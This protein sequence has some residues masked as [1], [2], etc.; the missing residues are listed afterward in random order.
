MDALSDGPRTLKFV[1]TYGVGLHGAESDPDVHDPRWQKRQVDDFVAFAVEAEELG[2]DGVTVTEH[3]APLM[4]CPSPHLLLAA[5]AVRTSRIRLGTAVTVLPLYHPIRVAE[6]AGTLDLLSGGR[7]ELGLGRGVPGEAH[8]AVGRRLTPEE[9]N[10]GWSESL[11]LLQLALTE[12]DFT[13]DGVFHKVTRPTTIATRPLQ[14]PFPIWLGGASLDTMGRA[15][16]R[17]WNVMRNF[18]S[19]QDHREA[20]EHYTK[21]AAEH[22]H[23]RSGANMMIERFVAVGE[24]EEQAERNLQKMSDSFGRFLSLFTAGGRRAVP[25][26]DAEFHVDTGSAKKN[27]PAI[28]VFGTPDQVIENL[29]RTID[30]TGARRLLVELFSTEDR[31][32]F[33]E[34]VM[35]VLRA[36]NATAR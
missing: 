19:N 13:Y 1:H 33:V 21:V 8:I 20:L 23:V 34:E 16:E 31:R 36:R 29:Q 22:G 28:A 11:E 6:E 26:S 30:E 25:Q 2:F 4:T 17:G 12:R 3:H 10:Q 27:R 35:P 32:L 24:S 9:Q 5:A 15:A 7:F 14:D 18:G